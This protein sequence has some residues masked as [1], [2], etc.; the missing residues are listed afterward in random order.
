VN[1][2]GLPG[3]VRILKFSMVALLVA[4]LFY[5]AMIDMS[6]PQQAV[7]TRVSLLSP[8]RRP[9][10]DRAALDA[11]RISSLWLPA[12]LLPGLLALPGRGAVLPN[13]SLPDQFSDQFTLRDAGVSDPIKLYGR[14]GT[15]PAQDAG[16]AIGG[17]GLMGDFLNVGQSRAISGSLSVAQ[18]GQFYAYQLRPSSYHVGR[19]PW[20]LQVDRWL[21][22]APWAV[23]GGV[24]ACC[25]PLALCTRGCLL[26]RAAARLSGL[27]K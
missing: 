18:A 26:R 27:E 4:A 14:A 24:L 19:L 5:P 6:W 3:P 16:S 20:R 22:Q 11:S 12:L 8:L 21:T 9:K 10:L 23:P 13:S 17:N 2:K 1:G 15:L 25:L 7:V